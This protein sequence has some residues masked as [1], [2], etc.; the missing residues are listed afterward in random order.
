MNNEQFS[1]WIPYLKKL[2]K[3]P[4]KSFHPDHKTFYLNKWEREDIYGELSEKWVSLIHE[5][6]PSTNVPLEAYLSIKL[7]FTAHHIAERIWDEK[8]STTSLDYEI[9]YEQEFEEIPEDEPL[10]EWNEIL[11]GLSKRQREVINL[12]YREGMKSPTE[13]GRELGISK[14]AVI[15]HRKSA[16]EKLKKDPEEG[17]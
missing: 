10:F 11:E 8:S 14:Q 5:Y 15:S 1:E 13:I 17:S 3:H 12:Y 9:P 2:S 16:L 7:S 6:D 4:L